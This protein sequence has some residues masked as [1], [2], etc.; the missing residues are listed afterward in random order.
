MRRAL[1]F[2]YAASGVL[3]AFFMV[4]MAALVVVQIV[5][6][7]AGTQVPSADDF[8][9]LSMAA[10]AFLGLAYALRTGAHIRVT[11]FVERA[12]PPVRTALEMICLAVAAA[13]SAWFA[14]ATGQTT[15][16]SW[17]FGEF[18]IGAIPIP[19]WLPLGGMCLGIALVAVAFLDDL[20]AVLRGRV[21]AY[22]TPSEF[23]QT[24]G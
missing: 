4:L 13:V 9:R 22:R 17:Q 11:L 5:A 24:E 21:P 7:L 6:R 15:V 18:T 12:P 2:L 1:R 10:S 23:Q 16:E 20:I 3:A 19:K 8:A 14:W